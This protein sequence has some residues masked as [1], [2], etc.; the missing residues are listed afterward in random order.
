MQVIEAS[1]AVAV[2]HQHK[3]EKAELHQAAKAS[4]KTL[5]ALAELLP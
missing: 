2:K 5:Q 3:R 1:A 4:T